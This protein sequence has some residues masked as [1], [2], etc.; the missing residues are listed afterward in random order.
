[1][2]HKNHC[3]ERKI[4]TNSRD[5]QEVNVQSLLPG[6]T[7][8]FRVVSNSNHGQGE[9]SEILEIAT[10]PEEN[11][12]AAPENLQVA[13]LSHHEIY[14]KWDPPKVSNGVIL[15]YRVFYA[16]GENGDDQ[17]A[18]TSSTEFM[19]TQLRAYCE[20]TV[21]VV[22]INQNGIGNPTEEKLVKTF[23][24]TPSEPPSNITLEAS[25]STVIHLMIEFAFDFNQ[26]NFYLPVYHSSMG[27][28]ARRR[29]KRP[30][31]RI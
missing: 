13:A 29:K 5:E 27:A 12:A 15:K 18:D 10:Q 7:Y 25:S 30:T 26:F 20:Y 11:I 8:H 1:M 4:S 17:F 14:L 21:S 6:K 28:T 16:E 2:R 22:S 24:N 9:S 3:R 19:L 23:S 31:Y